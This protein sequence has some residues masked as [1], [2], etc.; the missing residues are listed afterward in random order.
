MNMKYD[1]KLIMI[2]VV[3]TQSNDT[4]SV[5][6]LCHP[7][8]QE[9]IQYEREALSVSSG[10]RRHCFISGKLCSCESRSMPSLSKVQFNYIY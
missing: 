4:A 9:I 6:K 10:S 7:Q 3:S 8:I 1:D 2:H 5:T